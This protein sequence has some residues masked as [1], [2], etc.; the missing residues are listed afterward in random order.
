MVLIN[1]NP[2]HYYIQHPNLHVNAY[3][4]IAIINNRRYQQSLLLTIAIINNRYY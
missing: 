4:D 1:N 2:Y 3:H